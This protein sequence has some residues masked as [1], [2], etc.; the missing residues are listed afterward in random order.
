MESPPPYDAL[1]PN[2]LTAH[3]ESHLTSLPSLIRSSQQ[4]HHQTR[5]AQD[6][7]LTSLLTPP[8]TSLLHAFATSP[9]L[10]P[11][12]ELTL[13]PAAA[14]PPDW[15]FTTPAVDSGRARRGDEIRRVERVELDKG[16][17]EELFPQGNRTEEEGGSRSNA[18]QTDAEFD[19][20][21]RWGEDTDGG[22]SAPPSHLWFSNEALATRLA[23]LLQPT[24]PPAARAAPPPQ[25]PPPQPTKTS[26]WGALFTS[27]PPLE[28]ARRASGPPPREKSEG[29]GGGVSMTVR[30][31]EVS[32]RRENEL[33]IWESRNGYGIVVRVRKR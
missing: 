31:E 18:W 22:P 2:P 12:A 7:A 15:I 27:P 6:L 21:G 13:V 26:K 1:P 20:W 5:L 19:D 10:P 11:L 29:E 17:V 4:T 32:F 30:A 23:K 16:T 33:G 3:L 14:V 28:P 8:I 9:S 25:P 24:P